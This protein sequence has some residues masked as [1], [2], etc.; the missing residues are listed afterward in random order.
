[1]NAHDI[2]TIAATLMMLVPAIMNA[3]SKRRPV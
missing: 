3:M 2:A 1:M